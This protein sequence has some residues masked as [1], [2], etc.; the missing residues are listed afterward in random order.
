MALPQRHAQAPSARVPRGKRPHPGESLSTVERTAAARLRVRMARPRSPIPARS[1]RNP[2]C[3]SAVSNASRYSLEGEVEGDSGGGTCSAAGAWAGI[4]VGAVAFEAVDDPHPIFQCRIA[5]APVNDTF[6]API[7]VSNHRPR[8]RAPSPP[9][10]GEHTHH[11]LLAA[12]RAP[13]NESSC[14]WLPGG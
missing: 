10:F 7:H 5:A 3:D 4:G 14:P 6:C 8:T 13:E 11:Q 2:S 1:D 12:D 9:S